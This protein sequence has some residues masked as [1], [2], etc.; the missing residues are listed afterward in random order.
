[1]V[2]PMVAQLAANSV[3]WMV[4]RMEFEKVVLTVAMTVVKM[5][6]L[7]ADSRVV[8]WAERWVEETVAWMVGL[9]AADWA[10]LKAQSWVERRAAA[11]VVER[12]VWKVVRTVARWG[13]WWVLR[14]VDWRSELLVGRKDLL[15]VVRMVMLKAVHSAEDWG[16]KMVVWMVGRK[17]SHLVEMRVACWAECS[18]ASKAANL[19]ELMEQTR[20][21]RKECLKVAYLVNPMVVQRAALKGIHLAA[22]LAGKKAVRLVLHLAGPMAVY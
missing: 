7:M 15:L 3:V 19:A 10:V 12:A 13:K 5:D 14:T 18:A 16:L 8:R 9:T 11:R 6:V 22:K 20:A 21:E 1:L 17:D 4:V 2:G